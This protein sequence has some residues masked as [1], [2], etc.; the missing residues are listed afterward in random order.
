[1]MLYK[2]PK[3]VVHSLDWD[4]DFFDKV[5]G[6]F[7]GDE[8]VPYLFILCL[9]YDFICIKARSSWYPTEHMTDADYSDHALFSQI[10]Q[11]K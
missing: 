10:C 2:Y 9:D 3:A 6:V 8:S 1:M 5:A 11:C 4:M 7:K